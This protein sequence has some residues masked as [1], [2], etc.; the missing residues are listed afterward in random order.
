MNKT[1]QQHTTHLNCKPSSGMRAPA[2][3][4]L[5]RACHGTL[6]SA[7]MRAAHITRSHRK[8]AAAMN[9]VIM[10]AFGT[11]AVPAQDA[12]R[13]V[14]TTLD[15]KTCRTQ[16]TGNDGKIW[17]CTGL[18]GYPVQLSETDDRTFLT[19]GPA[20]LKRRA[21]RQ[22]LSVPN[23]LFPKAKR[24]TIEWRVTQLTPT[25]AAIPY[26]T[27]VRYFTARNDARG[28]V[29]VVSRVTPDESCHV[30][31]IDA[32]ANPEALALARHI[33]DTTARTF[34]CQKRPSVEG[35][36]GKSPM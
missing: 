34:D 7:F 19:V 1:N 15:L 28:Q 10:V 30:A 12:N 22:T 20:P 29:L 14:F 31:L 13:A 16:S 21:S 23:T 32:D 27:I 24:A 2:V 35:A 18:T 33:A 17:R 25:G 11:L 3:A 36:T 6:A 4:C 5:I 26:A 9:A 8:A